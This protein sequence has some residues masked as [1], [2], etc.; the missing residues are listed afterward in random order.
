[1]TTKFYVVIY[2]HPE[3]SP[4]YRTLPLEL[5]SGAYGFA[6]LQRLHDTYPDQRNDLNLKDV[7]LWKASHSTIARLPT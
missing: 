1:M 3:V 2:S 6:A 7:I 4:R 5:D